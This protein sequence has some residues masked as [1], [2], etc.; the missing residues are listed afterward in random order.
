MLLQDGRPIRPTRLRAIADYLNGGLAATASLFLFTALWQ[1]AAEQLGALIL[2]EPLTVLQR[3]LDILQHHSGQQALLTTIKSGCGGIALALLI[4]ITS[5]WC[6]GIFPTLATL[7]R[8]WMTVLLGMPPIIWVVLALFWF[9]QGNAITLFTVAIA[10]TPMLF[11]ASLMSRLTRPQPLL[12][13]AQVYRL[14]FLTRWHH[15]WLPHLSQ[16]LLPAISVAA[17]SGIKL[18]VMAELLSG[19]QGLGTK[20]ADARTMLDTTDVLAYVLLIIT[21]IMAIENAL[22]EPIK[23]LVLPDAKPLKT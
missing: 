4:G 18:T 16:T 3:M 5:G 21:I 20:I 15:I 17:G 19:T 23:R 7:L 1:L 14:P 10:I 22:L 8:P 9:H 6:A 13:M 12:E 2:P 11:A